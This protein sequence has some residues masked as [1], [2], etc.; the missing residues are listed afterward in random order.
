MMVDSSGPMVLA[1]IFF[2]IQEYWSWGRWRL[3]PGVL[4]P[5]D[6]DSGNFEEDIDACIGELLDGGDGVGGGD[7]GFNVEFEDVYVW[8]GGVEEE[9]LS[10]SPGCFGPSVA[11]YDSFLVGADVVWIDGG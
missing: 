2:S 9:G 1:V 8:G 5:I 11:G 10:E 7:F 4:F 6:E 3:G